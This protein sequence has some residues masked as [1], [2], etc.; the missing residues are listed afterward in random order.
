CSPISFE[1]PV[2]SASSSTGIN[3]DADTRLCSSNTA[4]PTVN[5]YDDCT[6]NAFSNPGHMR[7]QHSYC[8]SSEGI[9]ADHTPINKDRRSTDSGLGFYPGLRTPTDKTRRR[10]PGRG[11]I[12]NTD[13]ELRTRHDRPPIYE[14]TRHAR[15]RVAREYFLY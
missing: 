11:S 1:R 6:E 4:D 3:P 10:T 14:F 8:L 9:F 7:H 13:R 5:V 15:P 12:L 2:C